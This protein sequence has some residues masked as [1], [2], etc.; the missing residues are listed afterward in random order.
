MT[1]VGTDTIDRIRA[2]EILLGD[3]FKPKRKDIDTP[4]LLLEAGIPPESLRVVGFP[5]DEAM[6]IK[7]ASKEDETGTLYTALC[8]CAALRWRVDDQPVLNMADV[9][10]LISQ[11]IDLLNTLAA[12]ILPILGVTKGAVQEAKNGSGVQTGAAAGPNGAG[13]GESPSNSDTAPQSDASD[14]SNTATS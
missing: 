9:Q 3:R 13:G 7:R 4:P 10:A 6:N 11:D 14:P 2:R 8:V 12:V 5:A 1:Q